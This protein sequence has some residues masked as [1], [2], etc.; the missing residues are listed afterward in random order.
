MS[1]SSRGRTEGPGPG[2]EGHTALDLRPR[3]RHGRGDGG[4]TDRETDGVRQSTAHD[5][6]SFLLNP[7][8]ASK[9]R[10]VGKEEKLG[11]GVGRWSERGTSERDS[12]RVVRK[13][14]DVRRRA[15]GSRPCGGLL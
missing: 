1:H 3:P 10:G 11:V 13:K 9:T 14:E 5:T 15:F 7:V 12:V 2:A 4:E 6:G 8:P